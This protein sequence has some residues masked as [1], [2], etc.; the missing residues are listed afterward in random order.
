MIKSI[1][2]IRVY[3]IDILAA[4]AGMALVAPLG[5]GLLVVV[6]CMAMAGCSPSLITAVG[7][8]TTTMVVE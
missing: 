6:S 3:V 5:S 4:Q 2:E 7:L 8:A 1:I